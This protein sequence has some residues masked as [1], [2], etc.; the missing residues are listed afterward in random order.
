MKKYIFLI[1]AFFSVVL[2]PSFANA[3]IGDYI[4][5]YSGGNMYRV[6]ATGYF[7]GATLIAGGT[8]QYISVSYD[9]QSIVYQRNS[10]GGKLWKKSVSD[11]LNGSVF[12][13]Q[14][15]YG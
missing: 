12:N 10:D 2:I 13:A 8:P 14:Y 5:Y 11:S 15:S 4:V 3:A 7:T 1:F 6:N 9:G